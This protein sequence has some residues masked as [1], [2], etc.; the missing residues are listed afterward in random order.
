M[1]I[2]P[3]AALPNQTFSVTVE[4]SLY[5]IAIRTTSGDSANTRLMAI[6]IIRDGVPIV[7]GERMVAQFALIPYQ[8]LMDGNFVLVTDN[9]EYPDYEQFG[10]TQF[11]VYV[12]IAE[13]AAL[14]AGT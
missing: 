10:I 6:D 12:T 7:I 8:Y 4:E 1:E 3:L 13:L 2:V 11:L 14:R 5:D 9:D